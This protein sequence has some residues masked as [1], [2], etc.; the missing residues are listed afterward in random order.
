MDER[1]YLYDSC[2]SRKAAHRRRRRRKKLR[3]LRFAIAF[4]LLIVGLCLGVGSWLETVTVEHI[5]FEG[6]A[7]YTEEA[8]AGQLAIHE[9]DRMY[10]IDREQ[11]A[12]ALLDACPYLATAEIAPTLKGVLTVRVSERVARWALGVADGGYAILD[13]ELTVLELAAAAQ[14]NCVVLADGLPQVVVGESLPQTAHR[15]EEEAREARARAKEAGVDVSDFVIPNYSDP[16]AVLETRLQELTEAYADA[17]AKRAPLRLDMTDRFSLE[18]WLNDGTRIHLGGSGEL[19]AK[20]RGATDALERYRQRH[21]EIGGMAGILVDV[22]DLSR[23][24][25]TKKEAN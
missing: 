14:G 12:K 2:F 17:D 6:Q 18:L 3:R 24:S 13:A 25:I 19:V 22:S 1:S 21:P 23:I 11:A 8:L 7:H 10:A 16:V 4:C 15:L 5:L 20:Y 9:G